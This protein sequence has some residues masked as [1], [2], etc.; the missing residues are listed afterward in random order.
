MTSHY[1]TGANY[2]TIPDSDPLQND[3]TGT[4]PDAA[5]NPDRAADKRLFG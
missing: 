3:C 5:P 4:D 2:G 1:G